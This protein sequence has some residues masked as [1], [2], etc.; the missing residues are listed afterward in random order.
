MARTEL[1]RLRIPD[2][3]KQPL[4]E[5]LALSPE[6]ADELQAALEEAKPAISP[7]ALVQQIADRVSIPAG[8]LTEIISLLISLSIT[9]EHYDFTLEKVVSDVAQ[10]AVDEELLP[11]QDEGAVNRFKERLGRLLAL[12][13]SIGV[14]SRA[15]SILLAHQN[16]FVSSRILTD[17]RPIF[18]SSRELEPTAAVIVHSLKI[19]FRA[20]DH[21]HLEQFF[22]LDVKDLRSLRAMID[23]AIQKEEAL[24]GVIAESGLAYIPVE[25][26]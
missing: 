26:E 11:E 13:R 9:R 10:G 5:L 4:E 15:Q 8:M 22:A 25:T 24:K 6:A 18:S 2:A 14:S 19:E 3:Y 23:R 7:S 20:D 16:T 17:I 21:R 1:T 12:D